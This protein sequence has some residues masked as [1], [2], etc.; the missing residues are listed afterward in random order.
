MKSRS[1]PHIQCRYIS[2]P[3][4]H[5][6]ATIEVQTVKGKSDIIRNLCQ[7]RHDNNKY[8]MFWIRLIFFTL[9]KYTT[10]SDLYFIL[11]RDHENTWYI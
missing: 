7:T 5:R 11:T 1:I 8:T 6:T 4:Y 3:I 2:D 10:L 9:E